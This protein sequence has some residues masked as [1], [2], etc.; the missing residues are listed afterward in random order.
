MNFCLYN[1]MPELKYKI[2]FLPAHNTYSSIQE[3]HC[4][5]FQLADDITNKL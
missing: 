2:Y 4:N 5:M 3:I 1:K